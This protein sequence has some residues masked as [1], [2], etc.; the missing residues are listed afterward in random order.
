ML[1]RLLVEVQLRVPPTDITNQGAVTPPGSAGILTMLGWGFWVAFAGCLFGIVK[2]G[3]LIAVMGGGRS[4][5]PVGLAWAIAG[6]IITGAAGS[7]M[8]AVSP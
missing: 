6:A 3:G 5:H 7:I 8:L 2:S 1:N 4:E